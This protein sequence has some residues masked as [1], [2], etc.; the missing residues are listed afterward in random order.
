MHPTVPLVIATPDGISTGEGTPDLIL[1][2]KC[3]SWRTGHHWG[4][5]GTDQVPE[6]YLPQLMWEMAVTGLKAAHMVAYLGEKPLIYD[7][8]FDVEL[9]EALVDVAQQFWNDHV[10]TGLPPPVDASESYAAYLASRFPRGASPLLSATS[11]MTSWVEKLRRAREIKAAAEQEE[12][13]AINHLKA[14]IGDHE[15]IEGAWGRI[16]WRNNKDTLTTNWR[17][18]AEACKPDETVVKAHTITKPGPRVFRPNFKKA[19]H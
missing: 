12:A 13:E 1:E 18:V 6:Y 8:P 5:P 19:K 17:Q 2:V 3:P 9:F 4:E 7:V 15:G 16:T 10:A 14:A 11:E